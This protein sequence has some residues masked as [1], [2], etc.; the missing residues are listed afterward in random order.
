[1]FA[2]AAQD[3][4]DQELVTKR[5]SKWTPGT[6]LSVFCTIFD[7]DPLEQVSGPSLAGNLLNKRK[8]KF[9]VI[10]HILN[11]IQVIQTLFNPC[12]VRSFINSIVI[13]ILG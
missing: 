3:E 1:M 2:W 10:L 5:H 8:H 13:C 12:V 9:H 7:S 6:I 11:D 4:P